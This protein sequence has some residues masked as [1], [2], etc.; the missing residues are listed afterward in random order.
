[1]HRITFP[2]K[3]KISKPGLFWA[4]LIHPFLKPN[5]IH[6]INPRID[7][8]YDI[9]IVISFLLIL[10]IAFMRK[11]QMNSNVVLTGLF[12]GWILA[13]TALNDGPATTVMRML[14]QICGL[15]LSAFILS[16]HPKVLIRS[17]L[18]NM[19]VLIYLNFFFLL[20]YPHG[21]YVSLQN[22]NWNNWLLGYDN[23]W[24][25]VYFG[26]MFTAIAYMFLNGSFLRPIALI[27]VMHISAGIVMSGVIVFGM[28]IIDVLVISG[29]Y[30]TGIITFKNVWIAAI[31]ANIMLMF[32]STSGI[33]SFI[34]N[35]VFHK[36]SAS[37]PAR[38]KIWSITLEY[39]KN[40]W[41]FGYG[42][43]ETLIRTTMYH[44][45]HGSNAHN[46]LFEILYEGGLTGI[47]LFASLNINAGLRIDRADKSK[48]S[49]LLLICLLACLVTGSVDSLL[50]SRGALFFWMLAVGYNLPK[51]NERIRAKDQWAYY[52]R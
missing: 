29:L 12:F 15:V 22:G 39:V 24:F 9:C 8:I 49:G 2:R 40:N 28:A 4:V 26:A 45:N 46:F 38:L 19:E 41:L 48:F 37:I 42:R 7:K 51:I 31:A 32:F 43:Q 21:M 23:Q 14:I 52:L 34:I 27:T 13:V 30:K 33:A 16:D 6:G 5:G 18:L 11:R 10:L 36:T 35:N 47:L 50:E 20:R 25:I 44:N 1:M 17:M 3:I